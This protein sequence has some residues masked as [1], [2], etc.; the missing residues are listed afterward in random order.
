MVGD[1]PEAWILA[2]SR[3]DF[4]FQPIASFADGSAYGYEALLRGWDAAGFQ[5]IAGVFDC[6]Y[7]ERLLYALDLE[8]RRKAFRRFSEA[9]LGRAKL[10]YNIDNRLLEMPDYATGNTLRLARETGLEP[11]RIVF[12]LS[13]LHEP[14][15]GSCFDRILSAYRSQGFLIALDDFG[16]GYAGLKLLYRAEPDIVKID[17][18]FVGGAAEDPRK[19]SFLEKIAGMAHLMGISV[20][21]EG[22][23]TEVELRL[24]SDSGCDMAQGFFIA[25]PSLE[26]ESLKS[27]YPDVASAGGRRVMARAGYLDVANV[28]AIRAVT[29]GSSLGSDLARSRHVYAPEDHL[30]Y[31]APP[32]PSSR[33]IPSP[34]FEE[35]L[36]SAQ[37][38]DSEHRRMLFRSGGEPL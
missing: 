4:A 21:A 32:L 15:G 13:E 27:T 30:S 25:K 33:P 29:L 11:T 28:H 35:V 3:L 1:F 38:H 12:E 9:G 6:A 20:V 14:G 19:A 26:M 24:C 2:L 8:L 16:T 36:P 31:Q 18:Y 34:V 23:E 10:F 37:Y 22:I 5:S 7:E 17:R